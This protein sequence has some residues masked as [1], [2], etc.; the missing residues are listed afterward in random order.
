MASYNINFPALGSKS[1]P[2]K[3]VSGNSNQMGGKAREPANKSGAKV[4]HSSET[5]LT[6]ISNQTLDN[7]LPGVGYLSEKSYNKVRPLKG[8]KK[9]YVPQGNRNM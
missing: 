8:R 7:F 1:I 4:V 6:V 5:G 9:R 2:V 3:D